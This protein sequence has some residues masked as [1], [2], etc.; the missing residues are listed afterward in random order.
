MKFNYAAILFFLASFNNLAIGSDVC[1][2][3]S[4]GV[5]TGAEPER[6]KQTLNAPYEK[7]IAEVVIV[8]SEKKVKGTSVKVQEPLKSY[9]KH[10]REVAPCGDDICIGELKSIKSNVKT[11]YTEHIEDLVVVG[12]ELKQPNSS[13]KP[14][15]PV[16]SYVKHIKSVVIVGDELGVSDNKSNKITESS[17]EK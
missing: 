5:E 14:V 10:I 11:E 13:A 9:V 1:R 8:G 2:E 17:E 12:D 7:H 16:N 6:N 3:R 15:E 4:R